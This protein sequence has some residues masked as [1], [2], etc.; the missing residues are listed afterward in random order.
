[1]GRG[2]DPYDVHDPVS[3]GLNFFGREAIA[4]TLLLQL[5]SGE[6]IGLFGLRKM[7]KSSLLRFIQSKLDFPAARLDLL[8]GVDPAVLLPRALKGWSADSQARFGIT[9]SFGKIAADDT[10]SLDNMAYAIREVLDR[11]AKQFAAGRLGLILDEIEL[12]TPPPNAPYEVIERRLSFLRALRGLIQEDGRLS[13]LVAGVNPAINRTNR[14]G[15][16]A[17]QNPFYQ[18]LRETYLG[19]L[20]AADCV[21]MVRNIGCQVD[22]TYS[23][24]ATDMITSESGG[25]P[26]VARQFCSLAY[27]MRD[28]APGEIG[29]SELKRASLRFLSDPKYADFW[30]ELWK[31]LTHPAL[32]GEAIATLNKEVLW[33]LS[34]VDR[35]MSSSE[36]VANSEDAPRLAALHEL[37]RKYVVQKAPSPQSAEPLYKLQFDFFARWVRQNI[38]RGR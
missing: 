10:F 21:Q 14:W 7:G 29:S 32:W 19:P 34:R 9:L 30:A 16:N 28:G 33:T 20:A 5:S 3:D 15:A 36:I 24:D 38:P 22:L 6:P 8:A 12:I 27:S 23:Q 18:F 25:H 2:I 31:E 35:P 11:N 17:E 4:N 1:L 37:E 26:F 13:L